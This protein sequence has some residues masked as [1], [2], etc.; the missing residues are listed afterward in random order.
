MLLLAAKL[1]NTAVFFTR[2]HFFNK[3]GR[4]Y[5]FD[6]FEHIDSKYVSY[7]TLYRYLYDTT[8]ANFFIL[9][10][11]VAQEVLRSVNSEW[12]SYKELLAMKKKGTYDGKVCIPGYSDTKNDATYNINF[13]KKNLSRKNLEEGI[14][15]IPTTNVSFKTTIPIGKIVSVKV[16]YHPGQCFA[17]VVYEAPKGTPAKQDNGRYLAIYL[18]LN[19]LLTIVSNLPT[20]RSIII[21]GREMKSVN[22]YYNKVISEYTKKKAEEEPYFDS[23]EFTRRMWR[24][25]Y[26]K[27]HDYAHLIAQRVVEMAVS[28]RINTIVI[29]HNKR[30]KDELP[31]KKNVK[32]NFAYI[33]F[34]LIIEYIKMKSAFFGITVV[35]QDESYT[36]KASF[37]DDD[38][39]PT[40]KK[41]DATKYKFSG[42][43]IKR[44]LY[45]TKDGV[46]INADVNGA[47]NI[48][49]KYLNVSSKEIITRESMGLVMVPVRIK[50]K[51]LKHRS[52][53]TVKFF[54]K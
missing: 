31:F 37:L 38:F 22:R 11:T 13:F 9:P 4:N 51:E 16:S 32:Q 27:L 40:Y 50:V 18:G 52:R 48:L 2:Q 53:I 35:E 6:M 19:N 41:G 46:F 26:N 43:R 3:T 34:S 8:D 21:D 25:R 15:N 7:N 47:Y 1:R 23:D 33:P 49:K 28:N 29:G 20:F 17:D 12:S 54:N 44:G 30:W 5:S 14:V 10:S 42:T 36:S 24:D 45:K 39:I